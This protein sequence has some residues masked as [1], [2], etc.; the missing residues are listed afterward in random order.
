LCASF[1]M[2]DQSGDVFEGFAAAWLYVE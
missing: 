2:G 1:V